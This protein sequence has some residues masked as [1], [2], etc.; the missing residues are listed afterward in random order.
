MPE[1]YVH[2]A[3]PFPLVFTI[4]ERCRPEV[5]GC[6]NNSVWSLMSGSLEILKDLDSYKIISKF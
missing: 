2:V 1:E 6:K 3:S 5:L 4:S